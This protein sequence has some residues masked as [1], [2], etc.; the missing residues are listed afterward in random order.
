M[1]QAAAL[2]QKFSS[3][4]TARG[5]DDPVVLIPSALQPNRVQEEAMMNHFK[6]R[7]GDLKTELG[8][9]DYS[10]PGVLHE[11]LTLA[12]QGSQSGFNLPFLAKRAL[13]HAIYHGEMDWRPVLY[14]GIW[15]HSNM[16]APVV[17]RFTQQQAARTA[18][19]FFG[20]Q[21]YFACDAVG[22]ED[23]ALTKL[24]SPWARHEAGEAQVDSV[25]SQAIEKA[26]IGGESVVKPIYESQTQFYREYLD[27]AID[28]TTGKPV[29][30]Q[31][32]DYLLPTDTFIAAQHPITGQEI[33][34]L[35]RDGVTPQPA[36][37]YAFKRQ[38]VDRKLVQ[39]AGARLINVDSH[40]YLGPLNA[41]STQK[42]DVQLHLYSEQL[43]SLVSRLA[44][45]DLGPGVSP[46]EARRRV[47]RLVNDFQGNQRGDAPE[48]RPRVDLGEAD[49]LL[50]NDLQEPAITIAECWG[51]YDVFQDGSPA[52]V[53]VLMSDEDNQP[54]YY[55]YAA[56]MAKFNKGFAPFFPIRVNPEP[57]RWHGRGQVELFYKLQHNIDLLLNRWNFSQTS[58]GRLDVINR[59]AIQE[60]PATGKIELNSGQ[61]YSLKE[62]LTK[63]QVVWSHVFSNV[64][65]ADVQPLMDL[66]LQLATNMSGV[67]NA[68]DSRMAGLDTGELATGVKNIQQAG[69]ELSGMWI[70]HIRPAIEDV[71]RCFL[72]LSAE[73]LQS[74][75]AFRYFEGET[76]I[77]GEMTPEMVRDLELNVKLDLT[78][79]KAQQ[80]AEQSAAAWTV[81]K[82]F[83]TALPPEAQAASIGFVR[84]WLRDAYQIDN[85][86]EL[87]AI[88]MPPPPLGTVPPDAASAAGPALPP[89]ALTPDDT[90]TG[91]PPAIAA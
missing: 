24:L 86:D 81:I 42:M 90:S 88:A 8:Y 11:S 5:K 66:F 28:K 78:R 69:E 40:A 76:A 80:T 50:G 87:I 15:E 7:K 89:P 36:G 27:I 37:E 70:Q 62:P 59:N 84:K 20:T 75:R 68:N 10:A 29:I 9:L 67:A 74:P 21:P 83:Y 46:E 22:Q 12:R 73:T 49:G 57:N 1:T 61:I 26:F 54:L 31:G 44:A 2:Q 53:C 45:A 18:A 33:M 14:K 64:T 16:H 77:L 3:D 30:T 43:I 71:M 4:K 13:A 38:L 35:K 17:R 91:Q 41:A 34:V 51:W 65:S 85:A 25:L 47:G 56:N 52:Y 82:E 39:F 60:L 23:E 55:D 72:K 48:N 19:Y 58:S 63:E 32:G 79:Y 6:R